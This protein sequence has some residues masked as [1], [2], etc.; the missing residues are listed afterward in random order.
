M[1]IGEVWNVDFSPKVGDKISKIRPAVIVNNNNMGAL[2]LRVVV[3]VT[4][5][6]RNIRE[7]HVFLKKNNT[8]NLSKDSV[9]DCFQIKSLSTTRFVSKRGDLSVQETDTVKICIMKVLDLI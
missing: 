5:A 7:W 9:A 3:P 8:N 1:K 2:N 6:I 4:D